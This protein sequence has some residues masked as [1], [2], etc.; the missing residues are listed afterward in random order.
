M[1]EQSVHNPAEQEGKASTAHVE[2][3]RKSHTIP[4]KTHNG[5]TALALFAHG[6]GQHEPIDP[7]ENKRLVRRIDW[8]ILPFLSICY[9][10]YYVSIL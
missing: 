7:E 9:A 5:D 6:D 8:I 4:E 1:T 2:D 10:F 3:S